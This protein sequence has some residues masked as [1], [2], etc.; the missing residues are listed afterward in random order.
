MGRGGLEELPERLAYFWDHME[1]T[2]Y[3]YDIIDLSVQGGSAVIDLYGPFR[4]EWDGWLGLYRAQFQLTAV[5]E[6]D[7]WKLRRIEVTDLQRGAL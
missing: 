6:G 7:A 3:R 5:K 2:R 1:S 4:F